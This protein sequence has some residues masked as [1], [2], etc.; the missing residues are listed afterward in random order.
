MYPG[1][2]GLEIEI[3]KAELLL[4]I[5]SMETSRFIFPG[6]DGLATMFRQ[7]RLE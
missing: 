3:L 5:E 6:R 1:R 4:V 2:P 7:L